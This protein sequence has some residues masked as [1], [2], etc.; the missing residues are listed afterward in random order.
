MITSLVLLGTWRKKFGCK[1]GVEQ[2]AQSARLIVDLSLDATNEC[3][4]PG[5]ISIRTYRTW[6][7]DIRE[8][9]NL[10]IQEE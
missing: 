9:G 7:D 1:M 3:F 10:L 6:V 5:S 8:Y 4:T 2:G